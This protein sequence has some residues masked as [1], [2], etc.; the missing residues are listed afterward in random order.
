MDDM[1]T[2]TELSDVY[3]DDGSVMISI[4]VS[5]GVAEGEIVEWTW[6]YPYFSLTSGQ[7]K[8]FYH[9]AEKQVT[10][11]RDGSTFHQTLKF[12]ICFIRFKPER[13]RVCLP[14][15]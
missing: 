15:S 5:G 13:G 2:V 3:S 6:I 4:E 7:C 1:V 8:G 9:A 10:Y 12:W 14:L 11:Y